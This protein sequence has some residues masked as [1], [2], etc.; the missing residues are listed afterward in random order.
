MKNTIDI[1]LIEVIKNDAIVLQIKQ[2]GVWHE[3]KKEDFTD[4][5]F[6][7]QERKEDGSRNQ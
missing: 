3:V 5:K 7:I 6:K 1:Q 2:N 4:N